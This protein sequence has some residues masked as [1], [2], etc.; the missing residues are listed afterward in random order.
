M[1]LPTLR[2]LSYLIAVKATG[3]FS[4]AARSSFVTQS[5][6]S[7]GIKELETITG[8]ALIDR[9]TRH[10][11]LTAA[12]EEVARYAARILEDSQSLMKKARQMSQPMAGPL[13]LGVIPTVAP[14]FLPKILTPLQDTYPDLELQLQEDLTER[15]LEKLRAGA[16]DAALMAFPYDLPDMEV[17][18]LF[19]EPFYLACST[20]R[21][22]PQ[23]PISPADL[24]G[25]ELL[26]LEDGHCLR[27]HAL[28]ACR[29]QASAQ[30]KTFSAASLPTLI[31]MVAHGYGA[32]LLPAMAAEEGLPETIRLVGFK[33]PQ[34]ARQIGIAWKKG[35]AQGQNVKT[36]AKTLRDLL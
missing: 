16:L 17:E 20:A 31:Q 33:K 22:T 24:E 30:R 34:P 26:L 5:T 12:G 1:I 7:A 36:L 27:D 25:E 29:L 13:R 19:S 6:L 21:K 4:L 9:S 23:E 35:A 2:Q 32:T 28:Q 8:C 3:S 18:I 10:A 14:Y 11:R 15:L